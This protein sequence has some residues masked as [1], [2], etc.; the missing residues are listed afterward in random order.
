MRIFAAALVMLALTGVAAAVPT[1]DYTLTYD[2]AGNYDITA[3]ASAGDNAG[4]AYVGLEVLGV[5]TLD[6]HC[7]FGLNGSYVNMG[8]VA[9]HDSVPI[10]GGYSLQA[11]QDI[12][13]PA[14]VLYGIGQTAGAI[15]GWPGVGASEQVVWG[16]PYLVGSGTYTVGNEASIGSGT[17]MSNVFA[18]DSGTAVIGSDVTFTVVPEPATFVLL[19]MGGLALIRRKR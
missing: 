15:P 1:V 11:G 5:D 18:D 10:A 8:F 7:T 2:G 17:L 16:Q 14:S 9:L 4:I 19:A 13:T 12:M 6:N 3:V